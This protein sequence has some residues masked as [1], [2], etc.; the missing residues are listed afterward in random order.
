[1]TQLGFRVAGRRRLIA[2]VTAYA[3]ILQS[4]I[5]AGPP[6]GAQSAPRIFATSA[7]SQTWAAS[8][9][10][11]ASQTSAYSVVLSAVSTEFDDIS[12]IAAYTPAN[13]LVIATGGTPHDFELVAADG[14]HRAYSSAAGVAGGAR[15]ATARGEAGTFAAGELFAAQGNRIARISADGATVQAA[16]AQL[17]STEVINAI[18]VDRG[19]AFGGDVVAV[20]ASGNVWRIDA[21]AAATRV[22]GI[23]VP[24]GA[25]TTL[26]DDVARHGPWS[27]RILAGAQTQPM[28]YAV[29]ADGTVTAH[30]STVVPR[31]LAVVTAHENFYGVD[32][33]DRKVWGAP[34]EAFAGLVGDVVVAQASPG[35]LLRVHWNGS[36]LESNELARVAQWQQIAFAPAGVAPIKTARRPYDA[37]AVVN[38]APL[39]SSGRIEGA[40][41]QLAPESA[42]FDGTDVITSDFLVPGT[43]HVTVSGSPLFGGTIA[44]NGSDVPLTHTITIGGNATVGHVITRTDAVTMPAVDAFTPATSTRDASL[45]NA[46]DSA[47]D[48]ATL[49]NLTISGKAGAVTVPPGTYG[50]FTA[51]GRTAFVFGVAGATTASHYDLDSLTLSG[52]SE[53]LLAG[54]VVLTVN[55]GVTLTGSTIG[56]AEAPKQLVLRVAGGE[57]RVGGKSVLYAIVRAPRSTVVVDGGGR[58]RGTVSCDRLDV[59]G[60]IQLTENDVPPPPVNRPPAVDAGA[61]ATVTLPDAAALSGTASDDGLPAGSSLALQWTRVS[62]PGAVTFAEPHQASSSAAFAA[63]GTYVL[64][65]AASDGQLASSDDVTITVK[66]QNVAPVVSAGADQSIELPSTAPLQGQVTDDGLPQGTLVST[67]TRVIGPGTVTFADEHAATTAATF[68]VAG[69]Y[70]LRL[71]ATDGELTS[72]DDVRI[73]VAPENHPPVVSAGDDLF[74]LI[75][76]PAALSGSAGDDGLPAGSTLTTTWTRISGPGAV[77]FADASKPVTTV[78]CAIAGIYVLRLSATDGRVA[79]SDD[80]TVTVDPANT[81]PAANAGADQLIALPSTATLRGEVSDD[82]YPRGSQLTFTWSG[83]ASVTFADAHAKN[84]TATFASAGTYTL[85]L[86]ATDGALTT[87]DEVVITVDPANTAPVVNAGTDQLIALPSTASLSGEVSDDGYPRGS[88]LTFT[89]SG[90]A[91]V[92]FADAH[93]KN[94]TATFASAGTYTLTLT[95]TDGALTMNDEV[96]ITVDPQNSAPLVNAGEDQLIALPST[97]ALS[98][99]VSDDGYPRGSQL[100]FTWSGPASVTFADTHA[101]ATTA[102]F[103]A[104]GTYTLTLTATDGALTTSDEVVIAVDPANTAPTVS[105]GADQLIELPATA[106]LSAEVTDDGFPRGS[107]LTFTWSGPASVTFADLHAKD[108]TATFAAAGTYTLTL[109]ATDGA[110][111]TSDEVT[112]TVDPENTAP[113]VNAGADQLIELPATAALSAEVTDDGFPRGEQLTFTW[114][115]PASVSFADAQAKATTATFAAAGTYTLTLTATDGAL[116]SS[117][118]IVIEVRDPNVAPLVEAGPDQT[119]RLP[120]SASVAAQVSDDGYPQGASLTIT[121]TGPAGVTFADAHAQSTTA[122][123]AGPGTY[124]LRITVD[125]SAL[126]ASDELTVTVLPANNA[127]FVSAGAGQTIVLP[128]A[129]TLQGS[130]SDDGVPAPLTVQ[131][132]GP[133]GVT[134]SAPT[135]PGTSATFAAPGTYILTLTAS[136]GELSSSASVTIE[137]KAN[138]KPVVDAGADR[139][140]N[141]DDVV[142][143]DGKVTDDGLPSNTLTSHWTVV[144]GPQPEFTDPGSAAT[145]VIFRSAG[146]YILRLTAT[147]GALSASDDVTIAVVRPPVADFTVPAISRSAA[148]WMNNLAS[149]AAGATLVS[150]T[151]NDGNGGALAID[152][153]P[154][155]RWRSGNGQNKNQ[156]LVIRLAGNGTRPFDR[157]R[158]TNDQSATEAVKNFVMQT[159]MTTADDAAFTTVLTSYLNPTRNIQEVELDA[160]VTAKYVRFL[161][162]DN[163][164]AANMA[165]RDI[166]VVAPGLGGF[167][168]LGA[169]N[170]ADSGQGADVA[171]A[172]YWVR[173]PTGALDSN[174]ASWWQ[175]G[176]I[177]N[178]YMTTRLVQQSRVDRVRLRSGAID[179]ARPRDFKVEV[180]QDLAGPYTLALTATLA[181]RDDWQ[182]FAFPGGAV[183]GRF[184]RL[185]FLNNYGSRNGCVLNDF[186]VLSADRTSVSS[187]ASPYQRPELMF[188]NSVDSVWSP[189]GTVNQWFIVHLTD[190]EPRL[191]DAVELQGYAASAGDSIKDFDVLVSDTTDDDAAFRLV[192][193]GTV[194]KSTVMQ[195]FP[196]AGGPTRAR[197][198]KVIAKNNYGGLDLLVPTFH[199]LTIDNGGNLLSVPA[200]S[201]VITNRSPALAANGAT[202]VASTG[203]GAVNMLDYLLT[204]GWISSGLTNQYATIQ[205]AGGNVYTISGVRL[206]PSY[207]AGPSPQNFE[208]WVSST[209]SADSAFTK[210]LSATATTDPKIQNFTFPG[211]P[212]AARYVKY[213]PL[214]R[215]GTNTYIHTGLFDVLMPQH[216]GGAVEA[217]ST[218]GFNFPEGPLSGNPNLQWVSVTNSNEWVKVA[219]PDS[220]TRAVYG[221]YI[222]PSA[223]APRDFE[224]W[225]S[226]TTTDESAFTK[227]YTGFYVS[228]Q[229]IYRFDRYVDAKFVK[230]L[231]KTSN[232]TSPFFI[233]R[234]DVL[235][236]PNDGASVL[237]ATS[238]TGFNANLEAVIDVDG[239]NGAW[240]SE[241]PNRTVEQDFTVGLPGAK[242]WRVDH[243]AFQQYTPCC[244][245]NAP[246]D[247]EVQVTT[248]DG[249]DASFVTVYRG[250]SRGDLTTE[251]LFFPLVAARAVRLLIHNNWNGT[252]LAIQNFWVFS[253]Q[254]GPR[255]ARFLDSSVPGARTIVS[256][257]WSFGDGGTSSD[258]D[259][260]HLFPGPGTYDVALTVTDSD[261]LSTRRSM[262]YTVFGDAT[263]DFT[264]APAIPPEQTNGIFTDTST[265]TNGAILSSEWSFGDNTATAYGKAVN[266]TYLD[267][268]QYTITHKVADVRGVIATVT[269]PV[270]IANVPPVVTAG[271]DLTV[272]WNEPWNVGAKVSDV[273]AD[274]TTITC[275]WD[276][277]D[278]SSTDVT[279]CAINAAAVH[280]YATI[281]TFTATLT[282]TDKDGGTASDTVVTTTT[283]RP[284]MI[285]YGGSRGVAVDGTVSLA[286]VLRDGISHDLLPGTVTFDLSGQSIATAGANGRATATLVYTGTANPPV[287]TVRYDGDARYEASTSST[288]LTCPADQQP[289]D[290]AQVIDLSGSMDTAVPDAKV[291]F[292]NLIDSLIP[293]RDRAATIVFADSAEIR[294]PLTTD[295]DAARKAADTFATFGGGTQIASGIYAGLA[296]L[297]STRHNPA[298]QPVLILFSDGGDSGSGVKVAA[299]QAKAAGI[300]IISIGY[301]NSELLTR[302]VMEPLASSPSDYYE[303]SSASQL[304][305]LFFSL[306]GTL[307][308]VPNA[309]PVVSAGT[310]EPVALPATTFTLQGTVVDDGKPA[311]A[312]LTYQWTKVSGPGDVTFSAPAALSTT[313]TMT[314]AGTYVLRLT[315]SDTLLTAYGDVTCVLQPENQPPAVNAGPDM[316][317]TIESE[318]LQNSGAEA[319]LVNGKLPSWTEVAGTWTATHTAVEPFRGAQAFVSS[320]PAATEV[321]QDVDVTSFGG[322]IDGG[323]QK[324]TWTAFVRVAAEAVPDAAKIIVEYRGVN[325]A[326]VLATVSTDDLTPAGFW[327]RVTS[328]DT[329]PQ[330]TRVIRIRLIAA[331]HSGTTNDVWFDAVSLRAVGAGATRLL[332]TVTDDQL[333]QHTLYVNWTQTAGPASAIFNSFRADG[334]ITVFTPGLHSYRITAN[335]TQ[336]SASDD[337]DVT[338]LAGN[339]APQVSA[340]AVASVQLPADAT[341]SATA[342]D[343]SPALFWTWSFI[344]GPLGA[345]IAD[346]HA[347]STSVAFASAGT[348]VFRVYAD[349]GDRAGAGE[350]TITVTPPA[351]NQAPVVSAGADLVVTDPPRTATLN[352]SATDDGLPEG[353]SLTYAWS[354]VSGAAV[355]FADPA[356]PVTTVTFPASGT[357]VLRL[358]C[359]DTNKIGSDDVVVTVV[360]NKPPVVNAGEDVVFTDSQLVPRLIGTASDNDIPPGGAL[361]Y[362]WTRVSGPGTA[363]I[364]TPSQLVSSITLGAHGRHVFR[365]TATDGQLSA[366]D[367]VAI[368]WD[369]PNAAPTVSAGADQTITL[370]NSAALDAVINDD[371]LPVGGTLSYGW[372]RVSGPAEV[373]FANP[374]AAST[375]ATFTTAGD[376]VLRLTVTDGEATA[377]DDITI[378][379]KDAVPAPDVEITSPESGATIT[380]RTTISGS[381]SAG[382]TWRL[383]YRLNGNDGAATGNP[384]RTLASGTGP[385][386]NAPLA[387]FDPTLLVNG[388]YKVRLGATGSDGQTSATSIAVTVEG[389]LKLG[390]FTLSFR[391]LSVPLPGLSLDIDRN[392]DSRDTRAGDFGFGWKLETSTIRVEK[393]GVIGASWQETVSGVIPAVQYCIAPLFPRYVTVTFPNEKVYRFA[394]VASPQCQPIA[395]IQTPTITFVP[396]GKTHGTLTADGGTDVMTDGSIP[397]TVNLVTTDVVPYDPTLFRLTTESGVTYV[398]D[399]TKGVQQIIDRAGN[400]LTIS[401]DGI[402][403][404]SGRGVTFTRDAAG[405]ITAITDPE[406]K[407][408]TYGYDANGDLSTATD[409]TGRITRFTYD[410]AHHLVSYTDPANR[411]GIRTDYD[412]SGRM[413]AMTDANGKITKFDFDLGARQQIITDRRGN[414]SAYVYDARGNTLS[415]TNSDGKADTA[416]YDAD[417]RMLTHTDRLGRT[418]TYTYDA[419]GNLL[420]ATDAAGRTTT[421]TWNEFNQVTSETDPNG[422]VKKLTYDAAGNLTKFTDARGQEQTFTF[423]PAGLPLTATD[424]V[425]HTTAF[426]YDAFGNRTKV[427]DPRGHSETFTYDRMGREL[428]RTD[429]YRHTATATYDDEGRVLTITDAKGNTSRNEYDVAGNLSALIDGN[430]TRTET[431]A[432]AKALPQSTTMA[433][434][435]SWSLSYDPDDA[436]SGTSIT[437]QASYAYTRDASGHP[438]QMTVGGT[439]LH[440]YVVDAAGRRTAE[441]DPLGHTSTFEFDVADHI[442]SET[443]PLGNTTRLT[444]D[445]AGLLS[446]VTDAD[447]NTLRYSYDEA[448]RMTE[449]EHADGGRVAYGYDD[450]G[451]VMSLRDPLGNSTAFGRNAAGSLTLVTEPTGAV[452]SIDYD[453]EERITAITD[454]NE[455]AMR[456]AY[457]DLGRRSAVTYPDGKSETLSFDRHLVTSRKDRAGQEMTFDYDARGMLSGVHYADGTASLFDHSPIGKLTTV[458]S[459]AGTAS[460]EYD[461]RGNVIR[462]TKIDG[463]VLTFTYDDVNDIKTMTTPAGTTTYGYDEANRL[464]KVTDP[465]GHITTYTYDKRANVVRIDHPNGAVTTRQ[466]DEMS[467]VTAVT[468]A[469]K[470]GNVLFGEN[471]VF[472]LDGNRV[473]IDEADGSSATFEYDTVS[474]LTSESYW[475]ATSTLD[476]RVTYAYDAVGNR[477]KRTDTKDPVDRVYQ[478][479]VNDEM[480]SDGVS[481]FTYDA[482]GSL[483]GRDTAGVHTT[484]T[485]DAR[486]VLTAVSQPNG[487]SATFTY[488]GL[489]RRIASSENGAGKHYVLDDAQLSRVVAELDDSNQVT[490][491]YIYGHELVS[492]DTAAG[493]SFYIYDGTGSV[494]AL[495]D[496]NGVVTDRYDYDAFGQLTHK[497]GATPNRFLYHAQELDASTG[498]YHLR[499]R[500]YDPSAGRFITMDRVEGFLEAPATRHRY[501]YALN[502]PVNRH[503]PSGESSSTVACRAGTSIHSQIAAIYAEQLGCW[504]RD[505]QNGWGVASNLWIQGITPELI[506]AGLRSKK[507]GGLGT[508]PDVRH[509]R[510]GEVHEIKPLTNYGVPAAAA[511]ALGYSVGLNMAEWKVTGIFWYPGLYTYKDP[512]PIGDYEVHGPSGGMF[513]GTII[514]SKNWNDNL[515]DIK[516]LAWKA[517]AASVGSAVAA[518][519]G[520]AAGA[521]GGAGAGAGAGEL[522]GATV[523]CAQQAY[524]VM[525]RAG[526]AVMRDII[527][528]ARFLLGQ[529]GMAEE[530]QLMGAS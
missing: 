393:S 430:G 468:T 238:G 174:S 76:T 143:L 89:W 335:D 475:T 57:V 121:W 175:T 113:T 488:D 196:L 366:S 490:A 261:G 520:K 273:V 470:D 58:L 29:A 411:R 314:V 146:I 13:E 307:C 374:G 417:G 390:I 300:R 496:P 137:V 183:R 264:V 397:G 458:S 31:D 388:T 251:H 509:Y 435:T 380:D 11:A 95:A 237:G 456:F 105:A 65:L 23:G 236:V 227:V 256:W 42:L 328:T 351:G 437:G 373:Q 479:S 292:I 511:E 180:A 405:R 18:T 96:V 491:S 190:G 429:A 49:R 448:D 225:T 284:T 507:L 383:Q 63:P 189:T 486:K 19:G 265:S 276:F 290:V 30:Q 56:A 53:L 85:T 201:P 530:L 194:L 207:N 110:L 114:S 321:V 336:K 392:Y 428:S 165:V 418:N 230:F 226:N 88:Q 377:S 120:Q 37:L 154:Y 466:Y 506:A 35:V 129:A 487:P 364:A 108:T 116:T 46:T 289:L 477:S 73:E 522:A 124:V 455:H 528:G 253:P 90:T 271:P 141:V 163:Y 304:E 407:S 17:P 140:A 15:I 414:P 172:S 149:I 502:N 440:R 408:R 413:I 441:T 288:A 338:A 257:A 28:L 99:E 504:D 229:Q 472:D 478:Y 214:T 398:I 406:G 147:D 272:P 416:T 425:G 464:T 206:A 371:G 340:G 64:R 2:A 62:G 501:V 492:E 54:P 216:P 4:L 171:A 241:A 59:S 512:G 224:I 74:T 169:V 32:P 188:D 231:F 138:Q 291:A 317:A 345:V 205:L 266:H 199:V 40:L 119:V 130:A 8:Q 524:A 362:L 353:A 164:G 222:K 409:A 278:G 1:M 242:L 145:T 444:Y 16:W 301:K 269:R 122:T 9:T 311:G 294:Q 434:G 111:T 517:A 352:G 51:S 313:A 415:I 483:V 127:P 465:H 469:D 497:S 420:T 495:V 493:E 279:N 139:T 260:V 134:F 452:T 209:T 424:A 243:V 87:S 254:I 508:Q 34:A 467:R 357:Y 125:D 185:T 436:L 525:L 39:L 389:A 412:A 101:Q 219:L 433:D 136:D 322:T 166:E 391:D 295:L 427:T 182:D 213:V 310:Q 339:A 446:T 132:S 515:K 302:Q 187:T 195:R 459:P 480:L 365:L 151:S 451:S 126:Q 233:N 270:T 349:D 50:A 66:P 387:T 281:G 47:G 527:S 419:R 5:V 177:S 298:A 148:R 109:T 447:G 287:V 523:T 402:A 203:S 78:T 168:R 368:T 453:D 358:S 202:V 462:Q 286:A 135:S 303:I 208:I 326:S 128:N 198:V 367:D 342:T 363:T 235:T 212:V 369:G 61:D 106:A 293:G 519:L 152:D 473:E 332:A 71:T 181:D 308:T 70:V 329:V 489:D 426:E 239:G 80:V 3:L 267:S 232:S 346:P 481:T 161:L 375:T 204:E 115:G 361:A 43:P 75:D 45:S 438:T 514:Y 41:W 157:I 306:P 421:Y 92:T 60:T 102:T 210:V 334:H 382:A 343:E 403:H 170:V 275:H 283:K 98:G 370:P 67:W 150:D 228:S 234:L 72:S 404:S 221:V 347:A 123:F 318:L 186:Q 167:E 178:G 245:S 319:P 97:A 7:A 399:E 192:A 24:L 359:S 372:S 10:A 312:T 26:A 378:T 410:A 513:P 463:S 521:A 244:P 376:Y 423:T 344:S 153:N 255:N 215:Y 333:P 94:T 249:S 450:S 117:D 191:V 38:H 259:P 516:D 82:G 84:T 176:D 240:G 337:V 529:F 22:V 484:F 197:Y 500:Y 144:S 247:F 142:A 156:A 27:A 25:V 274:N 223:F 505:L 91:S 250:T 184:V 103:A 396:V 401:R 193:S 324:F 14:A 449:E 44:G 355:Q 162:V 400:E 499:A 315:A 341:L 100:T 442:T 107:Q 461:D 179:G 297:T 485:Y 282:A 320:G 503:D 510:T 327:E 431:V 93:A 86:T 160:P 6:L 494:R 422:H 454:A 482:N 381:V 331:R 69:S 118:D 395:P 474:R 518:L 323:Q 296:E 348:Y 277:G 83:P 262:Q 445:P 33:A 386:T 350:V 394:A 471:Y 268:G 159:S 439:L 305:P 263:A 36:E 81:A 112:I 20:T 211:G 133:A 68:S 12:G 354:T 526:A 379:V 252:S 220:A 316:T 457:D 155:T 460:Y 77:T 248:G 200:A 21:A 385:L 158:I 55:N 360:T 432:D 280:R 131:W 498:L 330:G 356:Q 52:G 258:R 217:S 299:D 79:I 309:A 218:T 104:A 476:R 325:N 443:D 384:W 48:F 285:T 246:R 173:N